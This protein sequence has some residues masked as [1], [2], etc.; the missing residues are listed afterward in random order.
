V[1]I[2]QE[3][4]RNKVINQ[5]KKGT[6]G[7]F[8]YCIIVSFSSWD[9]VL[10]LIKNINQFKRERMKYLVLSVVLAIVST[11]LFFSNVGIN[12]FGY[13]DNF[14]LSYGLLGLSGISFLGYIDSK[15]KQ[16]NN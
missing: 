14:V 3:I 1:F 15:M 12:L 5:A 13:M 10:G 16:F 6:N 4:L 8:S 2:N 7:I 9:K 11:T